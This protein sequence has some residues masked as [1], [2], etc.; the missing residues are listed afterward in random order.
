MRIRLSYALALLIVVEVRFGSLG[1][2]HNVF[3]SAEVVKP[4]KKFLQQDK[5]IFKAE[6]NFLSVSN[7][8]TELIGDSF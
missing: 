2:M 1:L 3:G 4:C 6:H 8:L 7:R 5:A